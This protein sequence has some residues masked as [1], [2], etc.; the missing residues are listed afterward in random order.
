MLLRRFGKFR[1]MA[2]VR[3]LNKRS[4]TILIA[5]VLALG[6]GLLAFNYLTTVN[7]AATVVAM[8]TVV[9]AARDIPVRTVMTPAMLTITS[10]PATAVDPD[11]IINESAAA[12]QIALISIP[13]GGTISASKIGRLGLGGLT[14][15]IPAGQRAI[16]I[17]LDRVKGVANLIQAG[18]HVDVLAVTQARGPASAIGAVSTILTNKTVLA[19]GAT[20]EAPAA[21][22]MESPSPELAFDT[23]TLAVTPREAK[24]LALAD[25]NSTLRLALRSIKDSR[26]NEAA[27]PFAIA[28]AI[29]ANVT[30]PAPQAAKPAAAP[31]PA[32][33]AAPKHQGP[34]LID[35]DRFVLD[36]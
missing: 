4:T 36:R 7:K 11:A 2:T 1:T 27:E 26:V 15:H 16:S 31:G 8:R 21:A 17:S 20:Q 28:T 13:A 35:G 24:I 3:S 33:S 12:G 6:T 19:M 23:A 22:S 10:R 18:D 14:M 32:A 5:A 25:L 34:P 29:P 9:V 30:A